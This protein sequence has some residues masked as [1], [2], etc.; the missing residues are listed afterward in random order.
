[1]AIITECKIISSRQNCKP[2]NGRTEVFGRGLSKPL[3]T[4]VTVMRGVSQ[5]ISS[6]MH[7]AAMVML[8][9]SPLSVIVLPQQ[10]AC[11]Q[12]RGGT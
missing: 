5:A 8:H 2:N 4:I 11:Q 6:M 10:A 3:H 7:G 12:S 9:I 1:M